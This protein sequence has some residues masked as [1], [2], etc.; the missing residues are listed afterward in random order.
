[1]ALATDFHMLIEAVYSEE[2]FTG[3]PSLPEGATLPGRSFNNSVSTCAV[4]EFNSEQITFR[5]EG[6]K[7]NR[8]KFEIFNTN[9]G[10][11][12]SSSGQGYGTYSSTVYNF[13]FICRLSEP[14]NDGTVV[15]L[16]FISNFRQMKTEKA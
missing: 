4:K 1:V 14:I 6:T 16:R 2:Q 12:I 13:E 5:V 9:N 10:E 15:K 11:L 8:A 7:V 3:L